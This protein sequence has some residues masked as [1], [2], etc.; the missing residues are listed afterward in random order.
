MA[1][2]ARPGE[3]EILSAALTAQREHVLGILD[4]LSDELL[5]TPVLPSGWTPL[6]LVQHLALD[7]EQF[8]FRM[9]VA[10]EPEDRGAVGDGATAAWQVPAG[11]PADAVLDGY[12]REIERADAIIAATP[13]DAGL[14]WWPGF[15]PGFR[16]H[17]LRRVI[18]HVLTE[19]ATH[20]GHLDAVRELIDGRTWLLLS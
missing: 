3:R 13:L 6:G 16:Y 18:V 19:T 17:D 1:D 2:P 4:G 8:W 11:V 20:A 15:F 9:V 14:A 5:R 12:R 7:V 10:G